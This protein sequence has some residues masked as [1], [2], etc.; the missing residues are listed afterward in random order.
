MD[1]FHL[2]NQQSFGVY[3]ERAPERI[4]RIRETKKKFDEEK[5]T[6]RIRRFCEFLSRFDDFAGK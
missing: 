3:Y 2:S 1:T 6:K 5:K 4:A